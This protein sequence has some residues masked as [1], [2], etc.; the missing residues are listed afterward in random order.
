MKLELVGFK[1]CPFVQRVNILIQHKGIP[2]TVTYLN[3]KEPPEWLA[4]LSPRGKVPLLKVDDAVLFESQVINEY[5]DETHPPAL[6]PADP[7]Q[8]ARERGFVAL[9]DDLFGGLWQ[10]VTAKDA[11]KASEA[12][13]SLRHLLNVMEVSLHAEG[14]Y[15]AGETFGLVDCAFAPFFM[16]LD[17]LEEHGAEALVGEDLPRVAA[18][19]KAL[20][21]VPA[22]KASVVPEFPQ[23]YIG[24]VKGQGGALGHQLAG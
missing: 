18:Y 8:R 22:V 10:W 2:C 5:L 3:P 16:R 23:L 19:R 12:I 11:D 14:P 15:F 20:A 1:I 4:A 7:L 17:V 9:A 6:L 24:F 21:A 13:N